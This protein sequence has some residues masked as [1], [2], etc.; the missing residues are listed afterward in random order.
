MNP[1]IEKLEK[2]KPINITGNILICDEL[3]NL[4]FHYNSTDNLVLENNGKNLIIKYNNPGFIYYNGGDDFGTRRSKYF[5]KEIIITMPTNHYIKSHRNSN[6]ME[7]ILLHESEDKLSY[8]FISLLLDPTDS[9]TAQKTI[10]YQLYKKF[11][12]IPSSSQGTKKL[13]NVVKIDGID[14]LP[15]EDQRSFYTYNSPWDQSI[16]WIVLETP[17]QVPT[18]LRDNLQKALGI[19]RANYADRL[20]INQPIPTNPEDL[21]IFGHK[22]EISEQRRQ[23]IEEEQQKQCPKPVEK[24]VVDL[25]KKIIS[26]EKELEKKP[27]EEEE[28]EEKKHTGLSTGAIVGIVFAVLF[29]IGLIMGILMYIFWDKIRPILAKL[30]AFVKG[31]VE[32]IP[33]VQT[34]TTVTTVLPTTPTTAPTTET[35]VA[36]TV[37]PKVAPTVASTV[38][39]TAAPMAATKKNINKLRRNLLARVAKNIS[40][41]TE[42]ELQEL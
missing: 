10:Q 32:Q 41:P 9:Q 5:L 8:Q 29:V 40:S 17:L 18:V 34:I 16:N 36:P 19:T 39:P 14:F 6:W 23:H 20:Q 15:D 31:I 33:G 2:H 30:F 38:A 21:I 25:E 35:T 42:I 13:E 22:M 1:R 11:K 7:L 4:E 37:A 3:C 28:E 12:D 24:S 27:Q 26:T